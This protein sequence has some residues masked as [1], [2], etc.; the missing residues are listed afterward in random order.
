MLQ[1][2]VCPSKLFSEKNLPSFLTFPHHSFHRVLINQA[3]ELVLCF[4]PQPRWLG[5]AFAA[6]GF[7]TGDV[8]SWWSPRIEWVDAGLIWALLTV[9]SIAQVNQNHGPGPR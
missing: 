4:L 9:L 7:G 3:Q 6:L 2:S 5:D 8:N 1:P